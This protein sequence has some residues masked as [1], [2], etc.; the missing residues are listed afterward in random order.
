[1]C[2]CVCLCVRAC[3]HVCDFNMA[4][5]RVNL[6]QQDDIFTSKA[7]PSLSLSFFLCAVTYSDAT[8]TPA[9]S[10]HHFHLHAIQLTL[11]LCLSL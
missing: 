5:T 6:Y 2:V 1:M 4:G 10:C 7:M 8:V 11:T 3:V 9:L